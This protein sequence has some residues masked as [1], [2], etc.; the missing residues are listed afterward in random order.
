MSLKGVLTEVT[1]PST[2]SS[3]N[4]EGVFLEQ[5]V[6]DINHHYA[7]VVK[8]PCVQKILYLN[9]AIGRRMIPTQHFRQ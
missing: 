2:W 3:Y 7:V 4:V 6:A 1:T 9:P 8:A 5:G